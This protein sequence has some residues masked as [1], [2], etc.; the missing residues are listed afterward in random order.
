MSII[1]LVSPVASVVRPMIG[2]GLV[3]TL[4]MVFKPLLSGL[5]RAAL[6]LMTPRV[7]VQGEARQRVRS[8][9]ALNLMARDLDSTQPNMA[10]ELR[11]LANR[12]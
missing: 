2:F 9:N 5:L 6:M 8:I 7:N 4:L 3:A 10:N 1:S 12:N 11:Q